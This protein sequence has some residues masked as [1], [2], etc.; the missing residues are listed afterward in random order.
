MEDVTVVVDEEPGSGRH[1]DRVIAPT[2]GDRRA[3][4]PKC[5]DAT[6]AAAGGHPWQWSPPAAAGG[7]LLSSALPVGLEDICDRMAS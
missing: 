2:P 4:Q 1:G 6:F 3:A 5:A 7:T